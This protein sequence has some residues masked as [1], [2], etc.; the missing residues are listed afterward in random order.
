MEL[1]GIYCAEN[2]VVKMEYIERQSNY[3]NTNNSIQNSTFCE[4]FSNKWVLAKR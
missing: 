2:T 3:T 1:Y 4:D